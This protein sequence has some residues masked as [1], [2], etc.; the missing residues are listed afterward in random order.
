[1]VPDQNKGGIVNQ[2]DDLAL[3]G[4][5]I[6]IG[7]PV[8]LFTISIKMVQKSYDWAHYC[9]SAPKVLMHYIFSIHTIFRFPLPSAS[10]LL[11]PPPSRMEQKIVHVLKI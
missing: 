1:M 2:V 9:T 4:L 7:Y 6:I 10:P 8:I 3:M 5:S 11:F